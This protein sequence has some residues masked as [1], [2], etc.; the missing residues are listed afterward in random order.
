[1]NIALLVVT[2]GRGDYL[3]RTWES[4]QAMLKFPVDPIVC[5]VDD[6]TNLNY[7]KWAARLVDAAHV[8][9]SVTKQGGGGAIRSAWNML[10]Y[11][12]VDYVFHLEDDW[13]FPEPV[14][15][16]EMIDVVHQGPYMNVV[17]RR[18]PWGAEGP[19]GY[20]G[21]NPDSFIEI[22]WD[23]RKWLDHD[24]GFSLN[25][26]IYRRY[27]CERTWQGHEHNFTAELVADGY[28]FAV[29]GGKDD[30]PRCTHI[31]QERSGNWRWEPAR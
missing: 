19:D 14:D 30:P 17:L 18:Q 12:D 10:R 9:F 31:G 23:G 26:S 1:M 20:I 7:S 4:A 15:V 3:E 16:G 22:D 2:D 8:R 6:S 11:L 28:R 25:P 13:T 5:L 27:L 24:H 29:L 21:D